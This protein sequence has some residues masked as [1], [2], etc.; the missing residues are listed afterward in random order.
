MT[1]A[2]LTRTSIESGHERTSAAALRTCAWE[3]R[4]S[5]SV[6]VAT[7]GYAVSISLAVSVSFEGVRFARMSSFG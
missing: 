7:P 2:L 4:S 1:P 3:L 6:R 5:S